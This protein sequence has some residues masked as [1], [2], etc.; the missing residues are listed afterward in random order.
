MR[1]LRRLQ[2][3]AACVLWVMPGP[4]EAQSSMRDVLN[5]LF[6]FSGGTDPLFLGGSA[7][8]P[9]TEVHGDHFIPS[10]SEANGAVLAFFN[11]AITSN[12]AHFPLSS[13][14]SS[15]TFVLVGGVPTPTSGSFGPIFSER[16]P[17]LGKGRFNA[18]F[19]YS[20]LSFAR[21]RGISLSNMILRFV[22]ENSDF[23][24]CDEVFEGDCTELGIPGFEH[25]VIELELDMRMEADLY[26]FYAA[27]GLTD[28][29]DLSLA[30]PVVKFRME[31]VSTAE[32]L[33]AADPVFHFFGGTQENPILHATTRVGDET[34][35]IGDLAGRLK[36]RFVR[37]EMIDV[38]VLG[39]IR[40]PTGR[41][42]DFL[43]TGELGARGLL[44]ASGAFGDF[45]PHL[46][47]GYTHRGGGLSADAIELAIGFDHR[48]APWATIAVDLLSSFRLDDDA[49]GFPTALEINQPY[50]R[51]I[52]RTNIPNIRDDIIDG[53][54]GMKFRT[55]S[56][57]MLVANA[58]VALNDG[59]L[60]SRVVPTFGIEYGR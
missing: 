6:V 29:L 2:C 25:D 41:E 9:N 46:N 24:N 20:H 49:I 21:M 23:P 39:E 54:I 30:V 16:A 50:R 36:A 13:T 4:V 19:S 12:I 27:V 10:E 31:G 52:E 33:P 38:A 59:G 5:Q 3:V 18:G 7:G 11:N 60:R 48:L 56:G 57:V 55:G 15:Q 58:L 8:I 53:S 34:V 37:S 35:G 43:G 42:E 26:A 28:W 22:H 47:A 1:W 44:I 45:S 51:V 40:V 14:V 32:I 17:T